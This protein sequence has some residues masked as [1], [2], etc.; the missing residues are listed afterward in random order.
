MKDTGSVY[1]QHEKIETEAFAGM[2]KRSLRAAAR[3]IGGYHD[4][5]MA[6]V[7]SLAFIAQVREWCD[8]A[9]QMAV[10]GCRRDGES[11]ATIA[12][13]LTSEKLP[14]GMTRQSAQERFGAK[15]KAVPEWWLQ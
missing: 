5:D 4:G 9:E 14:D 10:D 7:A 13:Y 15:A 12:M 11:W 3:R 8:I 2:L 6:D 1:R